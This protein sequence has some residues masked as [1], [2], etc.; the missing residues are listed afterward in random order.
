MVLGFYRK[1]LQTLGNTGKMMNKMATLINASETGRVKKI[2]GLPCEPTRLW[3]MDF[4]RRGPRTKAS[5]RGAGSYSNFFIKYPI[6]PKRTM[7]TILTALLLMLYA[8][9]TQMKMMRGDKM[10]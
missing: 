6:P 3:Q 7:I 2:N 4:S 5:I 9:M 1:P 8:P 10:A